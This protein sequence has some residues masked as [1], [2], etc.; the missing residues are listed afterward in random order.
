[1]ENKTAKTDYE[2]VVRAGDQKWEMVEITFR[3]F[4]LFEIHIHYFLYMLGIFKS[5]LNKIIPAQSANS[6]SK[7]QFDL[8]SF[9]IN[10][11]KNGSTPLPPSPRGDANYEIPLDRSMYIFH[12]NKA[13]SYHIEIFIRGSINNC[14]FVITQ[15]TP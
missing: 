8:S 3:I 4:F 12:C 11:L 1:M 13:R 5:H 14:F 7:S 6:H 9:Y 10:L 15:P 2:E